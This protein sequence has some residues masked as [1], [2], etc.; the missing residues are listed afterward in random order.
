VDMGLTSPCCPDSRYVIEKLSVSRRRFPY[1]FFGYCHL[2]RYE[3]VESWK[4]AHKFYVFVSDLYEFF[5]KKIFLF[6]EITQENAK[7]FVIGAVYK[8]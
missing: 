5:P 3:N 1:F 4:H 7:E 8:F 6:T 2:L